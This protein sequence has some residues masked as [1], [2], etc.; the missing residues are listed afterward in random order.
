M[1]LSAVSNSMNDKK[2][3]IKEK[4]SLRGNCNETFPYLRLVRCKAMRYKPPP[5]TSS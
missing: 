1:T 2:K 5:D 3:K 4:H